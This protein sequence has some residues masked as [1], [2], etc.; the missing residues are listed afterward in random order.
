LISIVR[1]VLR[2]THVCRTS[3]A[4]LADVGTHARDLALQTVHGTADT[5]VPYDPHAK[6]LAS[7]IPGAEV[8]TIEGGEHVSIFT[9]RKEV[10]SRVAQFLHEH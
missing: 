8:L 10:K 4:A 6:A 9:H 3:R 5:M 2:R 1:L 7:R